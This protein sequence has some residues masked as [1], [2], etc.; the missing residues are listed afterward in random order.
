MVRIKTLLVGDLIES[1]QEPHSSVETAAND[2]IN[3]RRHIVW[4]VKLAAQEE[5]TIKYSRKYH[6]RT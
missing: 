5:V 3:A 6:L 2:V 1:S 4:E